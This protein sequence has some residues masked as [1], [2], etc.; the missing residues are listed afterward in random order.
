[1]ICI[2]SPGGIADELGYEK[3]IAVWQQRSVFLYSTEAMPMTSPLEGHG[4][5]QMSSHRCEKPGLSLGPRLIRRRPYHYSNSNPSSSMMMADRFNESGTA[6]MWFK[7]DA[8]SYT[9]LRAHE[10]PEH[11]VC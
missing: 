6:K 11:L 4:G 9:H 7:F 10:T 2:I 1:M 5:G 3:A 8:V